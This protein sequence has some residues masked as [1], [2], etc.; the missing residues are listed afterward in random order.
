MDPIFDDDQLLTNLIRFEPSD[1][2]QEALQNYI[3]NPAN[4]Q[5]ALSIPD[6]FCLEVCESCKCMCE[7]RSNICSRIGKDDFYRKI[8]RTDGNHVIQKYVPGQDKPR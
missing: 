6:Q 3:N 4:Q 1:K 7:Q 2:E 5:S 8:S